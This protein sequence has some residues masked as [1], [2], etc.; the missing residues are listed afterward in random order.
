GAGGRVGT[1]VVEAAAAAGHSVVAIDRMP[2][3]G[4]ASVSSSLQVDMNDFGAV[5]GAFEGCDAVI[6]LAAI[7][8]PGRDPDDVVHNNNVVASYNALRAAA[9]LDIEKVSQAS[10]VNAIGGRFSRE[11]R[12]DYFPLDEEHPAYPED[13]YSLSKWE[14]EQQ[15][16]AIVRSHPRMSVASLR[17]H[18]IVDERGD[19]RRWLS[20]PEGAVERQ[21][22]GY[23]LAAASARA[24]VAGVTTDFVGHE[25]FYIVAPDT[26]SDTPSL[27]L[28]DKHYPDVPVRG[29][30][31]GN[32]GFFD[33]SRAEDILGWVHN[34]NEGTT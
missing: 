5:V 33:C 32:R 19:T 8:G 20:L 6:H 9:E 28:R 34:D 22:W 11:P 15:A 2:T 4:A 30:L 17:L 7:N 12:Y 24:F 21:L 14:C 1:A 3:D 13:P 26:M 16:D 25:R 29:D 31:A 27:E 10:S 18:G 23:T